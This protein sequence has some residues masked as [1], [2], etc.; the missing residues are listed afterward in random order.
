MNERTQEMVIKATGTVAAL[1][2]AWVVQ[3]AISAVWKATRGHDIPSA[4]DATTDEAVGEVVAAAVITGAVGALVRVL[5][6]R[7]GAKAARRVLA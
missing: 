2:A 3:R 7:G 1:A 5:A 4:T 6:T